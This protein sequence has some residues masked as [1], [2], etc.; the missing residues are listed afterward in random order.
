MPPGF[1]GG[2]K[3]LTPEQKAAQEKVLK[4]VREFDMKPRDVKAHLD[5]YVIEQDD[6]K[7]VLSVAVCDHYNWTRRCLADKSLKTTNYSKPNILILGPTGSGKTYLVR[8]LA[9]MLGVPFVKA[10]ATKFSETGIVGEDAE[11]VVR[12]LVDAAGGDVELAQYGMVYIDE[13]DKITTGGGTGSGGWSG[14]QVQSNFLKIMEE[15]E[16]SVKNN[17]RASLSDMFGGGGK[18]ETVSTKFILFIFSGAFTALNKKLEDKIG[19]GSMGFLLGDEANAAASDKD[20]RSFLHLAETSDFVEAGLEPEF[21]GRVPVR[22]AIDA[23]DADDL[24]RILTEA[25]DSVLKQYEKEFEGY[26]I[27]LAPETAALK[28]AAKM[29][30][31]EKTGARAL[32]TVLEK[33]LRDFKFELPSTSCKELVVTEKLLKEPKAVLNSLLCSPEQAAADVQRWLGEVEQATKVRLELAEDVQSRIVDECGERQMSAEAVLND[34]FRSTGALKG[35][36]QIYDE[37]NGNV[38]FFTVNM[39]FYEK[40]AEEIEKWLQSLRP[41]E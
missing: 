21:I 26:G 33:S 41:S 3:E 35:F 40:P 29:A 17:L 12:G 32:V 18:E 22:V 10:D 14:R 34:R 8:T 31:E 23:L 11:D 39:A 7:K 19:K 6:A 37:T 4:S 27:R 24:Y 2:P 30:V 15:T 5:R 20:R 1:G 36:K 16:V 25:E 38:T 28:L 9:K 13:V